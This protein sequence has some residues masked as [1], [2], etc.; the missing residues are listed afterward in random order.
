MSN[1]YNMSD[2][3]NVQS[4]LPKSNSHIK[5]EGLYNSSSLYILL[6]LTPH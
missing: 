2:L 4:T 3:C 1:K 6:F 5:V